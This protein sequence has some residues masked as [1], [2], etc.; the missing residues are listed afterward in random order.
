MNIITHNDVDGMAARIIAEECFPGIKVYK[1]DNSNLLKATLNEIISRDP[2]APIIIADLR[3]DSDTAEIL[4]NHP[5]SVLVFDHHPESSIL[6]GEK[7]AFV[8]ESHCS[9]YNLFTYF[10]SLPR[11]RKIV[12]RYRDFIRYV[13]D[14][15]LSKMELPGS[16]WIDIIFRKK[17]ENYCLERFK[18][19]S[20]PFPTREESVIVNREYEKIYK[21]IT[22][23]VKN[24]M[25]MREDSS[26]HRY[27][28]IRAEKNRREMAQHILSKYEDVKYVILHAVS[29]KKH[30]YDGFSRIIKRNGEKINLKEIAEKYT[31]IDSYDIRMKEN[32]LSYPINRDQYS[33]YT[34][35]LKRKGAL[36]SLLFERVCCLNRKTVDRQDMDRDMKMHSR[37]M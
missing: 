37:D 10:Q 18:K 26:G 21:H 29:T 22:A 30:G 13:D 17:G 35:L 20:S 23:A 19:D 31:D 34:R 4:K 12:D 1:L 14:F 16:D 33:E 27:A 5:S 11:Y 3:I 9:A 32:T 7:W 8:D 2:G 6:K 25:V 15:D 36:R 24:E 28:E